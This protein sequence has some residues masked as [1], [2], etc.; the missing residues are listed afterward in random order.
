MSARWWTP[1]ERLVVGCLVAGVVLALL[2]APNASAFPFGLDQGRVTAQQSPEAPARPAYLNNTTACGA[3]D[4]AYSPESLALYVNYSIMFGEI[5][6]TPQFVGYYDGMGP[7]G[8]LVVG[9]FG[10]AGVYW[11][12]AIGLVWVA[13]CTNSSMGPPSAGPCVFEASWVGYLS[14]NSVSGPDL[15]EYPVVYEGLNGHSGTSSGSVNSTPWTTGPLTVLTTSVG[16]GSA[17]ALVFLLAAR[18][19]ATH[20][21][22]GPRRSAAEPA[23]GLEVDGVTG[24]LGCSRRDSNPRYGVEGPESLTGLDYGSVG[25]GRPEGTRAPE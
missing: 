14:N 15:D 25:A 5:C 2:L 7:T 22:H 24:S 12:L 10:Q 16:V 6:D 19:S 13:N 4:A 8:Y 17:T 23:V 3:F 9:G 20:D 1:P 21:P 11:D 18:R